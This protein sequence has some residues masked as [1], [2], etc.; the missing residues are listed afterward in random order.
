MLGCPAAGLP[1]L[2]VEI[3]A[4]L[5]LTQASVKEIASTKPIHR[6]EVCA[7]ATV[8]LYVGYDTDFNK[9]ATT[10]GLVTTCQKHSI[11]MVTQVPQLANHSPMQ[12]P[13]CH[14][15]VAPPQR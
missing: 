4:H 1:S 15:G 10:M 8:L 5:N 3:I 12:G 11:N 2:H 13:R 6:V 7:R 9:L 14:Q